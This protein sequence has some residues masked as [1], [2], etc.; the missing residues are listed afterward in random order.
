M[1]RKS[2]TAEPPSRVLS[3]GDLEN[4]VRSIQR[5][6][7]EL[8]AFDV[9]LVQKRFDPKANALQDKIE[10]TLADIF[11][12]NT[13]EFYRHRVGSLDDLPSQI[14][15]EGP[16]YSPREIQASY[17][18]G[19][20]AAITQLESLRD[21]LS[22]RLVDMEAASLSPT[23]P[24]PQQ[25][26][27]GN[28]VFIVHGHDDAAKEIMARFVERLGLTPVILHEQPN[29]GNTIIEKLLAHIDVDFTV[30]LLTPDDVG[31]LVSAPASLK[32]RARQNVVFEFGLFVGI[33]GRKKVCALYKGDVELPSDY[34]GVLYVP[35]D[36]AGGWKLLLAREMR[37]AGLDVDMNRAA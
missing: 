11:G 12:N 34:Q 14:F 7:D 25:R 16:G 26:P 31:S 17:K 22:E 18:Q 9:S 2:T 19:I 4:A 30:V 21:L 24:M 33:L 29:S 15:L 10:A 32:S 13:P 28:R 8:K 3:K 23:H 36:D 35:M 5:R 37:H 1:A 6:I 20:E 27:I